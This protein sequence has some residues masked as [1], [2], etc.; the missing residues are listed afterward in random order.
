MLNV[1]GSD[2]ELDGAARK[3]ARCRRLVRAPDGQ[4]TQ[5]GDSNLEPVPDWAQGQ[6]ERDARLFRRRVRVPARAERRRRRRLPGGQRRLPQHHP[7]ARRRAQLR[8][9]RSRRAAS[10]TTRASTTRIRARSATTCSPIAPTAGWSSTALDLPITD[11]SLAYGS[12]LIAA[13]EGEGWYA[14]EGRN[15]LL[16]G[17]G[18]DHQRLFLY[19]PGTALVIVDHVR[20]DVAHTYTRYLQLHPDDRARRSRRDLDPDQRPGVRRARSTTPAATARRRAPR[21]GARRRR[22]RA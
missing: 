9:L 21:R 12:G 4:M 7:Q 13:G 22:C 5:F 11:P 18:V 2:A 17:Q 3:D 8:A 19:R 6:V 14:I 16:E 10:S 15:R 1:L 20:S